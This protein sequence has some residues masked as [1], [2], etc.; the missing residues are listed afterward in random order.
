VAR[1]DFISPDGLY[2]LAFDN[3]STSTGAT[4][5]LDSPSIRLLVDFFHA[6]GL[7]LLKKEDHAEDWYQDWIDYQARHGLYATLL[8]P[9]QYSTRGTRFDLRNY[10]RFL[11]AFAYFS[12]AHAY[13]LHVS[14]L[15]LFPI[16]ISANE[17]LKR[18]AVARLEAGGLFAFAVSEKDHGSDLLAIEFTLRSAESAGLYARGSKYYI[19]NANAAGLVS[20]L[21]KQIGPDGNGPTRR[22]PFVFFALRPQNNSTFANVRKIRTLGIRTAFVAE[23]E[24]NDHPVPV[25][26]VFSQ[27]REAWDT[28]FG[29]VDFG[30][31]FLGFGAVGIC[32]RA[33]AEA[34]RHLRNRVLYGKPVTDMPHIRLALAGAFARLTG[35]KLYAGRALDYFQAAGPDDRRYL[36]FNAVQKARVSTEGVKVMGL[37]SE[38]IGAK[39]FEAESFFE[40][41]LREAPMIPGLEGST[42]INF[43][44]TAQFIDHYFANSADGPP[45]PESVTLRQA[46]PEENPYWM[47]PR[48]RHPK[49]VRFGPYLTAYKALRVVPNVRTFVRQVQVF[50]D[51][52]AG[53]G[54]PDIAADA[55]LTIAVGKCF[56]A[57]VYGQLVAEN[58]AAAAVPPGMASVIFHGL[59]EDLTI[60]AVRLATL[61]PSG[62]AHRAQLKRIVRVP[63]TNVADVAAV[64][65]F[66]QPR[67]AA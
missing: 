34:F 32:E 63:R 28:A 9:Q 49:T 12:P 40:T 39:G 14:F 46:D 26:D 25:E 13:S 29:T 62:S 27:G 37:L 67:F 30:K 3:P 65:D 50:R 20:V 2:P 33:F 16:L 4:E 57:V 35:M 52:F 64:F 41:A 15:G 47:G 8:S 22:S 48:D 23:F 6:K 53:D 18:E 61:F 59:I 43:A 42:H 55:G 5:Y 24:V 17:P 45:P 54:A 44:L 60:E 10:T 21:G 1:S 36:L 56:S 19:G 66:L 58:C 7:I 38:S 11:E 51:L 31:F